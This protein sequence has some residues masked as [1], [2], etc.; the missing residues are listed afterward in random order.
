MII[1][2][3]FQTVDDFFDIKVYKFGLVLKIKLITLEMI[4]FDKTWKFIF[5]S[6]ECVNNE[7]DCAI[8]AEEMIKFGKKGVRYCNFKGFWFFKI[9]RV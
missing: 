4:K 7:R 6:H 3:V 1:R 5:C 9:F 8:S 2:Y